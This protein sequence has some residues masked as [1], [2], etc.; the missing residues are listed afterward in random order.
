MAVTMHWPPSLKYL[1]TQRNHSGIERLCAL[2]NNDQ[3][4]NFMML[5]ACHYLN[6]KYKFILKC[7]IMFMS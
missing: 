3:W 4:F 5:P 2:I 6:R 7:S 1:I